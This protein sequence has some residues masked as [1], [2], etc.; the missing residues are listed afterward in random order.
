VGGDKWD[1]FYECV[2]VGVCFVFYFFK[3][4]ISLLSSS[5]QVSACPNKDKACSICGKTGHLAAKCRSA[6]QNNTKVLSPPNIIQKRKYQAVFL[7]NDSFFPLLS[8]PL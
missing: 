5:R 2:Y 3:L 7:R 1:T 6:A 8:C 4:S